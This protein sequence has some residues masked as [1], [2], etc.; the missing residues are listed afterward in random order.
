MGAVPGRRRLAVPA[1]AAAALA[2]LAG[3]ALGGWLL[4]RRA[5]TA[6][7]VSFHR[8]T[9]RRGN[10]LSAR[11]TPDGQTVAYAA[12]WEGAPAEIFTVR[13]DGTESRPLGLSKADVG[14]ISS[15]GELAVLLKNGELFGTRGIGTL[16]R[17]P[18]NGGTPRE[19]LEDVFYASWAP[20]GEDLAV[21]HRSATGRQ[22]LE[23]PVGKTLAEAAEPLVREGV[24][25]R[26]PGCRGGVR[27]AGIVQHLRLR[28]EGRQTHAG[29]WAQRDFGTCVVAAR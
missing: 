28:L 24:T 16:A 12:A 4:L 8:L 27:L 5:P 15:K 21:V 14:S 17:V 19:V 26:R 3:G 22:Q 29:E 1:L 25:G 13:T 23:Y 7:E 2:L 11:F 10:L 18:L 6:Q 20:N 9:F